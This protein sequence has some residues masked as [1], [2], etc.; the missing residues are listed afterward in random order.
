MIYTKELALKECKELWKY[1]AISG[2]R[3]KADA[4]EILYKRGLLSRNEYHTDCP[5]C[6]YSFNSANGCESCIW[7]A[8]SDGWKCMAEESPFVR[9]YF[10]KGRL[11]AN[12]RRHNYSKVYRFIKSL[13]WR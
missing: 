3:D 12:E 1:I 6:E 2:C 5:L 8:D 13:K 7:P 9:Y 10:E 4:I 11:T